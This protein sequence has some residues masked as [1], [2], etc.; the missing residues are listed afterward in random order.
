[1]ELFG[2]TLSE[3]MLQTVKEGA[4]FY[5][6]QLLAAIAILIIGRMVAKVVRKVLVKALQRANMEEILVSFISNI[7]Y[8]LMIT[9]VIIAALSKLG[10]QTTSLIAVLGAAGLAIGLA[11]QGSLSNFASGVMIIFFRYFKLGDV[12]EAGGTIGKVAEMNIFTTTLNTPTNDRVTVP[13]SV[14]T[15]GI[16]TNFT[17]HEERRID[18]VIG[19][20]YGDDL[21]KVRKVL[22]GLL[23]ADDRI[24]KDP[25]T[26][27]VMDSLGDSSV[28]FAVRFWVKKDD[29][30]ATKCDFLEAVK[31]TFDKEG[32]NIPYPQREVHMIQTS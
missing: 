27:I 11:L 16:M 6:L 29:Y 7:V 24:L 5:G 12:I 28:N 26:A 17:A 21:A 2:V 22:E 19:V 30:L 32:I 9:F 15:S 23:A 10:V 18:H 3:E 8:I 20:G 4:V 31:I 25:E 14:F 1:M 13:N